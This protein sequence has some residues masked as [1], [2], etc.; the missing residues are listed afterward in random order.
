MGRSQPPRCSGWSLVA[1]LA[2]AGAVVSVARGDTQYDLRTHLTADQQ[3]SF[4]RTTSFSM[5][6]T[7]GG[8][9]PVQQSLVEKRRGTVTVQAVKDGV[10]TSVSVA[11]EDDCGRTVSQ[12]GQSQEQPFPLAGK[13]VRVKKDELGIVDIA[14]AATDPQTTDELSEML[15]PDRSLFPTHPVA[16]GD[17]WDGDAAALT[18]Q[19]NLGPGFTVTAKCK[20]TAIVPVDGRPAAE[21][22]VNIVGTKGGDGANRISLDGTARVDLATGQGVQS[23]VTGT[24]DI[25]GQANT[26]QGPQAV[27]GSGKLEVRETLRPVAGVPA[28][29]SPVVDA[30]NPVAGGGAVNP[31]AAAAGDRFAGTWKNDRVAVEIHATADGYAGTIAMGDHKFPAVARA[32]GDR[33]TG[34]FQSGNDKFDFTADLS[35]SALKLASGRSEFTLQKDAPANPLDA[36]GGSAPVN[37]LAR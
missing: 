4:R 34:S 3:W 36:I 33:L 15:T 25:S 17:T 5:T 6:M 8:G 37:P 27:S 13:T 20:L 11:F 9:Q 30:P 14:G 21:I 23:D 32:D 10:P 24:M 16:V 31:L 2:L 1:A 18:K 29:T 12:N 19:L 7:Q 28:V 35:G 22:A 26:P